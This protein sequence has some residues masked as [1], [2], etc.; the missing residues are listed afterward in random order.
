MLVRRSVQL[1]GAAVVVTGLAV[2]GIASWRSPEPSTPVDAPV[3][4]TPEPLE[5]EV[6]P[7]PIGEPELKAELRRPVQVSPLTDDAPA[8][9][10]LQALV[11]AWL[12]AKATCVP[13][14]VTVFCPL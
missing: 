14:V 5:P 4:L 7:E 10:D 9:K 8:L 12:D 2:V 1:A 6:D 13:A 11:Q 3:V